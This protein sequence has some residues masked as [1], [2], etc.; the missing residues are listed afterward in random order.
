MIFHCKI[1]YTPKGTNMFFLVHVV[2]T[3]YFYQ[4]LQTLGFWQ[5]GGGAVNIVFKSNI[6]KKISNT[7]KCHYDATNKYHFIF[8]VLDNI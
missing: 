1:T 3:K 5:I 7:F 4:S 6:L 8:A 2:P